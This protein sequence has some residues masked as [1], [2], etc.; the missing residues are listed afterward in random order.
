MGRDKRRIVV[1]GRPLLDRVITLMNAVTGEPPVLIGDDFEGEFYS[2]SQVLPDAKPQRGPLGGL[3]SALN[4]CT[5]SWALVLPVDLPRLTEDALKRLLDARDDGRD[6]IAFS[7][8]SGIQPLPALFSTQT[9]AFW[10]ERLSANRLSLLEGFSYLTVK[11]VQL[12][13]EGELL[14]NLNEPSDLQKLI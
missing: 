8:T 7:I 5:A 6:V 10:E 11:P 1:D 13:E 14:L 9:A 12:D 2:G 3:V 4:H